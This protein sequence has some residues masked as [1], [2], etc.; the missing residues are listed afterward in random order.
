MVLTAWEFLVNEERGISSRQ[1]GGLA[2]RNGL[3][4]FFFIP[5]DRKLLT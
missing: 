1:R 3:S 4:L 5:A 2:C